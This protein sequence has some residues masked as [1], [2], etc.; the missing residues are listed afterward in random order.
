VEGAEW[1][2]PQIME[3]FKIRQ[4]RDGGGEFLVI[5]EARHEH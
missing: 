1:W 5:A 4:F 3:R 2:L